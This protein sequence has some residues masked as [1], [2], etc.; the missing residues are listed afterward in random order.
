MESKS[1]PS[2]IPVNSFP[3][4]SS[5]NSSLITAAGFPSSKEWELNPFLAYLFTRKLPGACCTFFLYTSSLFQLTMEISAASMMYLGFPKFGLG[6]STFSTSIERTSLVLNLRHHPKL[7][8][9][10]TTAATFAGTG[11]VETGTQNWLSR[12]RSRFSLCSLKC[13]Q[14]FARQG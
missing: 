11:S 6:F 12:S 8:G 9:A 3:I 2:A 1:P 10:G 14:P 4:N 5:Y 7:L 13:L